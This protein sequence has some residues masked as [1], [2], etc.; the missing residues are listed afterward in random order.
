MCCLWPCSGNSKLASLVALGH[1]LKLKTRTET[2]SST[3]QSDNTAWIQSRAIMSGSL[4]LQQS[5]GWSCWSR[6][7]D[8]S[9]QADVMIAAVDY[10]F[11]SH[12]WLWTYFGMSCMSVDLFWILGS[13]GFYTARFHIPSSTCDT[14]MLSIQNS[15]LR[16]IG[17]QGE[18]AS[19][20]LTC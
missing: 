11:S 1:T 13:A 15:G 10:A 20:C 18:V 7:P 17:K 12:A 5:K 6:N 14:V 16:I 3:L 19:W 4:C 9:T 2:Y 8:A